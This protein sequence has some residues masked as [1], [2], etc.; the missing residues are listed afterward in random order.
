M[1][2][3]ENMEK[4]VWSSE[5]FGSGQRMQMI[6]TDARADIVRFVYTH[7]EWPRHG[8]LDQWHREFASDQLRIGSYRVCRSATDHAEGL[9]HWKPAIWFYLTV[10]GPWAVQWHAD[11]RTRQVGT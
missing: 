4:P 8:L 10:A 5:S 3:M 6:K 7:D 9:L 1:A 2:F 11:P